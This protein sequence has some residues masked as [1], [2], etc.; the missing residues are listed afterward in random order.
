MKYALL[1]YD[2]DSAWVDLPDEEKAVL[3]A[4]EMPKWVALFEELGFLPEDALAANAVDC[5]V[6]GRGDDPGARVPRQAVARP[7]LECRGERVLHRVLGELEVSEDACEDRDGMT[8]LL[9]E[10]A[11]DAVLH[12]PVIAGPGESRWHRSAQPPGSARRAGSPRRDRAA[13]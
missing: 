3:R 5:P 13:P 9:P 8:P 10:D 11:L 2:D 7:A 4:E 1:I 12:A 6:A